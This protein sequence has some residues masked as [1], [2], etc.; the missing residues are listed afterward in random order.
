MLKVP[1]NTNQPISQSICNRVGAGFAVGNGYVV[2]AHDSVTVEHP[3]SQ[4]C[5]SV[6]ISC[7]VYTVMSRD[8][9]ISKT[10][11]S[12]SAVPDR[13]GD[14]NALIHLGAR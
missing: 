14:G 7:G 5:S 8:T 2:I 3:C 4:S 9:Q 1:L 10:I 11:S 13:Y 12:S 6:L